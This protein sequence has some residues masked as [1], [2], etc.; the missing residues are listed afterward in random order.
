MEP[1]AVPFFYHY[2]RR[3]DYKAIIVQ[4]VVRTETHGLVIEFRERPQLSIGHKVVDQSIRTISIPWDG[5]QGVALREPWPRWLMGPRMVLRT[6]SLHALEPL[7][8]RDGSQA[9]LPIARADRGLASELAAYVD[10]AVAEHRL[11]ALDPPD[12]PRALPPS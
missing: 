4:G 12:S 6:R 2:Q 11:R 8:D 5:L 3:P 1:V 7:P 9:E 10:V